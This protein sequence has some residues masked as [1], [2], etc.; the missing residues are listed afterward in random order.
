M[1]G[2]DS[3]GRG[4]GGVALLQLFPFNCLYPLLTLISVFTDV[5]SCRFTM[6]FIRANSVFIVC[7][8]VCLTGPILSLHGSN[9]WSRFNSL[10]LIGL[11]DV[12]YLS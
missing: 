6:K 10:L 4:G 11:L 3:P 1:G 12:C 9:I 7:N 5:G 8:Q 2:G